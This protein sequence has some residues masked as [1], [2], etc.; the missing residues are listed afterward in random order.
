MKEIPKNQK[1]YYDVEVKKA[2]LNKDALRSMN[3]ALDYYPCGENAV[4]VNISSNKH[5]GS[6][7]DRFLKEFNIQFKRD[8]NWAVK[9]LQQ[10]VIVQREDF[11]E[12]ILFPIGYKNNSETK[13]TVD[14]LFAEDW[15]I[16]RGK[17]LKEVLDDFDAGKSIRRKSWYPEYLM[18]KYSKD[19]ELTMQDLKARDWEVVDVIAEVNQVQKDHLKDRN[20]H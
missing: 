9:M 16:F 20:E 17:S 2:K 8:I 15:T 13:L 3:E 12:V 11:P 4:S 5:I 6:S 18:G 14:D 1:Y 19:I 10:G 7:F